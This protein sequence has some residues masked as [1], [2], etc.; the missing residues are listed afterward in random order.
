M[1]YQS[2]SRL[3]VTKAIV[4]MRYPINFSSI[5]RQ[6]YNLFVHRRI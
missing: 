2:Q 1:N 4:R 6:D 5:T 3:I